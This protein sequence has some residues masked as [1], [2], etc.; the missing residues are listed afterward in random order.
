MV[1]C[2]FAKV[3][4]KRDSVACRADAVRGGGEQPGRRKNVVRC[5]G[6]VVF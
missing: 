3:V 5:A 6:N 2:S 4:E 1:R